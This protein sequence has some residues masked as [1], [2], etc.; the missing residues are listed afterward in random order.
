MLKR[1]L[2]L[3]TVLIAI[4]MAAVGFAP[5]AQGSSALPFVQA[6]P[7]CPPGVPIPGTGHC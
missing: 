4:V 2:A 3:I 7:I 6:D 5:V 1:K